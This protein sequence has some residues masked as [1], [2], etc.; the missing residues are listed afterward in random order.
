VTAIAEVAAAVELFSRLA[1]SL[2]NAL[3]WAQDSLKAGGGYI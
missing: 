2:Q 1:K 3:A